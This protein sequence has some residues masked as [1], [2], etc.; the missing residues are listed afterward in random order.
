VL[1]V[2]AGR[3]DGKQAG[4]VGGRGHENRRVWI[5]CERSGRWRQEVDPQHELSRLVVKNHFWPIVDAFWTA[6][7]VRKHVPHKRPPHEIGGGEEID[8]V[9][10]AESAATEWTVDTW[11]VDR[12][13]DTLCLGTVGVPACAR[14]SSSIAGVRHRGCFC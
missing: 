11:A 6:A 12:R 8:G 5:G 13:Y 4:R 9:I 1:D 3:H 10:S 14:E 2:S 7:V